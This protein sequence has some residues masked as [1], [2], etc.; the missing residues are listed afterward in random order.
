MAALNRVPPMREDILLT[1]AIAHTRARLCAQT[2]PYLYD[3][4]GLGVPL[5]QHLEQL[6]AALPA[7]GV[8]VIDWSG[9]TDLTTA[10]AEELGPGILRYLLARRESG[11]DIYL[12]HANVA[13]LIAQGLANILALAQ[14]VSPAWTS[15]PNSAPLFL[16]APLPPALRQVLTLLYAGHST[17]AALTVAGVPAPSRKLHEIQRR[18]PHLVRCQQH[19]GGANPRA[20]HYNYAPPYS[21][22]SCSL[23]VSA[24]HDNSIRSV[25]CPTNNM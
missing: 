16:G 17:A 8:L 10:I 4:P 13:P 23:Q 19:R 11:Q 1:C 21:P 9:L 5:R 7:G 2:G 3:R 20:W 6:L 12:L 18:W 24:E 25:P 15:C 14:L 22:S